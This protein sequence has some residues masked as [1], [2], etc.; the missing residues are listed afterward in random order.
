MGALLLAGLSYSVD[1]AAQQPALQGGRLAVGVTGSVG[2]ALTGRP[3]DIPGDPTLLYGTGFSGSSVRFG[4]TFSARVLPWMKANTEL[5]LGRT[6]VSGFA[7]VDDTR[8]DVTFSLWS[9][10]LLPMAIATL[11]LGAVELHGGLGVG[12]RAGLVATATESRINI[13][14]DASAPAVR[15]GTVLP[16]ALEAGASVYAGDWQIQAAVRFTYALNYPSSTLGRLD[17]Y[18]SP[19]NPGAYWVENDFDTLL[20]LTLWNSL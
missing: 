13:E 17:S 5:T 12:I 2:S 7:A 10:Q 20:V 4:P 8:R 1:A 15:T 18:Q 19:R 3:E 16:A 6:Q 9:I 14:D 11:D